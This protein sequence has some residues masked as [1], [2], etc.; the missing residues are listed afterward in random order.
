[1]YPL[2][3]WPSITTKKKKRNNLVMENL[4]LLLTAVM[5]SF[6]GTWLCKIYAE[7]IN[8]LDIPNHRSS[9]KL[10]TPRGGGLAIVL[11]F[12]VASLYLA[13]SG[14][15]PC[16]LTLATLTCSLAVALIG[17]LDDHGHVP[18]KTRLTLHFVVAG[19]ALYF[20]DTENII[21]L[22]LDIYGIPN[23]IFVL[24]LLF[25][26]VWMLN[27]F[28][29]MDGIDGL[30]ALQTITTCVSAIFIYAVGNYDELI[31]GPAFLAAATAG[32]LIWNFPPAR[33]FM[34]DVGSGF[35]GFQ[36]AL[37]SISAASASSSAFTAWIILMGVFI[38]DAT[39]TLLRRLLS[40]ERVLDA[41]RSHAYQNAAR[42]FNGHFPVSVSVGIINVFW[43]LPIAYLTLSDLVSVTVGVF[44][45]YL[46]LLVLAA[47]FNAGRVI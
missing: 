1:M 10:P 41:H 33:V 8:M 7:K 30:A 19:C 20:M 28:N 23:A 44:I 12:S 17:F 21:L 26:C 47:I 39:F 14:K 29:F 3:K 43:L 31:W 11:V 46:P 24:G 34:G 37:F 35:I 36:I 13:L 32:F 40:R 18:A 9:H 42:K 5:A 22:N 15:V 25:Y 2:A 6:F 16:S 38:T 4:L 45:A 27:L